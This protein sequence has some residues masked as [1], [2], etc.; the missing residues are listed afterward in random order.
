MLSIEE[1][2]ENDLTDSLYVTIIAQL[3]VLLDVDVEVE[4]SPL[5]H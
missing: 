2:D 4:T 3:L 1:N 5:M